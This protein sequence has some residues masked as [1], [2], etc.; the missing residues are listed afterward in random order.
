MMSE[1]W[2]IYE[3]KGTKLERKNT[4]CP[5]CGE[6]I[7]LARHKDRDACGSCGYTIWKK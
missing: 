3:V 5:R 6:G 2:K 4:S 7:F 1:K